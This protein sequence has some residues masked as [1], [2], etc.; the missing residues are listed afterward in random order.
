MAKEL[1]YQ[2]LSDLGVNGLNTQYNPATLSPTFLTSADNVMI[3][4]SGRI[5]FR[6]GFKQKVVPTGTAIGSMIEHNDQGTN[7]IFA[8]FGTSIYTVDFTAPNAAFASGANIKRTVA[9]STGNWQF[10]NFNNRLHCF[11]AGV[12]TQRY[13]GASDTGERWSA[14]Q[15]ATA[16]N[17]GSNINN[18]VTTITVD[19]TVGFPPEGTLLIESEVLSYTSITATTFV[20]LTRGVGSSSAATHNND[21]AVTSY[22]TPAGVT[23]FNPSCGMGFYGRLW[24]GGI[25]AAKDVLYYSVLLDGDDWNG[26]GSGFIDLKTVWNNDEIVHIAP[27]FGKL[28][29]FGK[30]NIAIYNT[31]TDPANMALD[32]VISGIGCVNRDSVQ[33]IGDDLV[34][35]SATGLRSLNRTTEKENL[36]L[37]DY[38]LNIKDT[39]IRNIGNSTNVKS[40]YL[41]SEGVY[42]LTFVDNNITYVFDFKQF[43]PNETPRVTTWSFLND[44]EPSAMIDSEL[45]SGLMSG[46]KDGGI[47]SYEGFFDVDMSFVSSAVVLTNAPITADISSIWIQMGESYTAALLKRMVLVLQGG[48]G[49]ILGLKW[50]VD[51]NINPSSTVQIALNP[52]TSGIIA[53]WGASSSLYGAT[54]ATHT[55]VATTHPSNSTFTPVYGLQEYRTSLSGSAKQLKLNLSIVS[56]G[57]DTSIQDLSIISKQ[58]KIR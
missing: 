49:A 2:P 24:C 39:L 48:S 19:S 44:R 35:L 33:T 1:V 38:S 22:A 46:Q 58:G 37:T 56:N 28:V 26:T 15:N 12:V 42:I 23:T 52:V 55:H 31:P 7:K 11:H 51:Y 3:R 34:F 32:E 30:S 57:Y 5:S 4:E 14:H 27:F 13:S 18:S 53:L 54:T 41:E 10:V 50:Y 21:V 45:Y 8:S 25:S 16:I 47:A 40:V 9:N 17:D 29:I 36:P 43:T 20:G 6:K